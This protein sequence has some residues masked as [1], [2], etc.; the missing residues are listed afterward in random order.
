M[1]RPSSRADAVCVTH[2]KASAAGTQEAGASLGT[3][4]ACGVFLQDREAK[5]RTLLLLADGKPKQLCAGE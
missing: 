4:K 1:S 5:G 2:H 3:E